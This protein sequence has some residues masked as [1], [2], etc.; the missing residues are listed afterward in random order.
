[1][2]DLF[3][4]GLT[5]SDCD[6]SVAFYRDV[7]GMQLTRLQGHQSDQF[8]ELT[9][10]PGARL[11]VAYLTGCGFELQLIEYLVG[12]G[13]SVAL[14]HNKPGSLHMAFFVADVAERFASLAAQG[15]VPIRSGLVV[16]ASKT[17]R[18]FYVGDP[19]G[20]PVE[21]LERL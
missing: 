15:D 8:D 14:N 18:S 3:H 7:V 20:V 10:N 11:K 13:S 6:R 1:M 9:D 4:I 21:F 17:L 19:D 2:A 16:N 5:V 12:G